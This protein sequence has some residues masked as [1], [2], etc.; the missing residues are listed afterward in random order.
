MNQKTLVI[1]IRKGGLGDHLFYSH[2]PRIAKQT[3]AFD[4][5]FISNRSTVRSREFWKLVW[6]LNPFVDGF[7]DASGV[8][9][10][11]TYNNDAQNMLDSIMLSYGLDDGVRFHEPEV[12]YAPTKSPDLADVNVYD[13]N[14]VSGT[15]NLISGRLMENYFRD[16]GI[17]IHYQMKHL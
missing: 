14:Y 4:Q 17:T 12:F 6:E 10:F 13:P 15:G 1:E 7:T 3:G 11:T 5:V 9:M 16:H 8:S 2:L